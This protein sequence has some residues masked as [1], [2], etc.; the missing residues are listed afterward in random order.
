MFLQIFPILL[1]EAQS[2]VDAFSHIFANFFISTHVHIS[3]F[4][5]IN[6]PSI[7]ISTFG[8]LGNYLN[9]GKDKICQ[10]WRIWKIYKIWKFSK[11]YI[12]VLRTSACGPPE[13]DTGPA[14]HSASFS[15]GRL[16]VLCMPHLHNPGPWFADTT[17]EKM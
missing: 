9:F 5:I 6:S 11:S 7:H 14:A 17:L 1:F 13:F 10:I 12:V 8:E 16:H 15:R 3:N 2:Y 4:H